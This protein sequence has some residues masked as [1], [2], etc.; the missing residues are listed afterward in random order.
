M[1]RLTL[2]ASACASVWALAGVAPAIAA[3]AQDTSATSSGASSGGGTAVGEIV[4]TAERREQNI[5]KSSLAISVHSAQ[6][7][8]HAGVTQTRDI[9]TLEPGV[10]IGQGGPVVQVYVRGVGDFG[11]TDATNPAVAINIDGVYISRGNAVEGNF[12]DLS[13]IEVLKGP[14]GTLYG[15]NASG[16]AINL[17]TN[18]PVLDR[19]SGHLETEVGD[20]ALVRTE[21]FLNIPIGD[22]L[23]LR[24]AF[25]VISRNGYDSQGFDD[26]K[27]QSF[28]LS[29]LWKPDDKLSLRLTGDI[30]HIGGIGPAYGLKDPGANPVLLAALQA[31]GVTIPTSPRLEPISPAMLPVFETSQQISPFSSGCV[32][33]NL[34]AAS[35]TRSGVVVLPEQ[36]FCPTGTGLTQSPG[37][38]KEAHQNNI[39]DNFTAQLDYDLGFATLTVLP[40]YRHV[41]NDYVNFSL[42]PFPVGAPGKPDVSDTY[43]LETRLGHTNRHLTWVAGV[44]LYKEVQV[45]DGQLP[46]GEES[47]AVTGPTLTTSDIT[48]TVVAGFGQATY[49][50][51]D[52]WRLIAGG[53]YASDSKSAYFSTQVFDNPLSFTYAPFDPLSPTGVGPCYLHASPCETPPAVSGKETTNKFTYKVGTEYDITPQNMVYLTYATGQKDG[54]FNP[55]A[56]V[57]CPATLS[58]ALP[59]KPEDLSALELGS[60]NLFFDSRLRLNIEGFYWNYKNAQETLIFLNSLYQIEFGTINAQKATI[61]GVDVSAALKATPDDTI[62]A[63]VELLHSK[64]DRFNYL[65][66]GLT[67]DETGCQITPVGPLQSVSCSGKPLPRAPEWSGS[68]GYTHTFRL[69]SGARIDATIDGQFAASRY[70]DSDFTPQSLAKA[71]AVGNVNVTYHSADGKWSLTGFVRNFTNA[72]AYTGAFSVPQAFRGLTVANVAPPLTYGA[73]FAVDF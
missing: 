32:P 51:T 19:F 67:P 18:P 2:F 24:P 47:S 21:G 4:V 26:D 64:F 36:G 13:R 53:R 39:A 15:R 72:V 49:S 6:E 40:A 42:G 63:N 60:R 62:N 61:Y 14:Q 70:L 45:G 9:T 29:A 22:T 10:Q 37:D 44:Y 28:R 73:R 55:V 52:R 65:T 31:N 25:Q 41:A 69:G 54:G 66:A 5:Q 12:F 33:N 57:T 16:G 17:I 3:Q 23:A 1:A 71:Y 8:V 35:S 27:E 11:S 50:L 48:T 56:G 7:L 46:A 59:Y 38:I 68:A 20:Y 34:P 30:E 58:C 43:S